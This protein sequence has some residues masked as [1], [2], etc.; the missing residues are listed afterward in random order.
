MENGVATVSPRAESTSS[1]QK[2]GDTIPVFFSGVNPAHG[3]LG[4][5]ESVLAFKSPLNP[6]ERE[7]ENPGE[8][9]HGL[10]L[11]IATLPTIARNDISEVY[12]SF[13]PPYLDPS[14]P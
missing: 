14:P 13:L 1:R 5:L 12:A 10:E 3:N 2:S 4:E 7:K 11:Q 6:G 9:R 8:G